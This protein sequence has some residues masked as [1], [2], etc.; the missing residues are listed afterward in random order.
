MTWL[1][2]D[3]SK[4][5]LDRGPSRQL[6]PRFMRDVHVAVH[7]DVGDRVRVGDQEVALGQMVVQDSQY[8]FTRGLSSRSGGI[9][10]IT[11]VCS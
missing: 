1:L 11:S 9:A 2:G 5:C 10:G 6:V 7:G 3:T 4:P 8:V